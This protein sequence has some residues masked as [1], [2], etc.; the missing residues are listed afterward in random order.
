MCVSGVRVSV[1]VCEW[2]VCVYVRMRV[3]VCVL[4]Q[5]VVRGRTESMDAVE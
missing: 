4:S 5:L 1:C 2:C 3:C